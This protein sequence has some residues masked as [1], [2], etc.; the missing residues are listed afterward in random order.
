MRSVKRRGEHMRMPRSIKKTRRT[1]AEGESWKETKK[2]QR[3]NED[4]GGRSV[5]I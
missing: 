5:V 2:K 3:S 1:E 4:R